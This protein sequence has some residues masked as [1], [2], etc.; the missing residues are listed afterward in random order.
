[1]VK[2]LLRDGL[3]SEALIRPFGWDSKPRDNNLLWLDKNENIDAIYNNY[4]SEIPLLISKDNINCY[5]EPAK[6]YHKLSK[7]D[8]LVGANCKA[9]S[10][11]FSAKKYFF[12]L[13][14]LIPE[15]KNFFASCSDMLFIRFKKK[16][17]LIL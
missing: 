14:Y 4:I 9:F 6:L 8:D 2:H 16:F 11:F 10:K 13:K 15:S 5:Q 1:M 3:S 7:I 12:S 17:I